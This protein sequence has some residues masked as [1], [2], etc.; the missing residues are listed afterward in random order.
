VL[1][2]ERVHLRPDESRRVTVTADPRVLARFDGGASQWR[3]TN[4]T[5]HVALGMSA[6]D[7][8]LTGG[9]PLTARLFER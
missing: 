3:I 4:G 5:Y 2:F 8:V 9:A 1:G 6:E 7:L